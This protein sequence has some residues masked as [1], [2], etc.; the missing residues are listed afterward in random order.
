MSALGSQLA[1]ASASVWNG[2]EWE[3]SPATAT[4]YEWEAAGNA[5]LNH[6]DFAQD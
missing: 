3:S 6:L 1:V 5:A 2:Y 4:G